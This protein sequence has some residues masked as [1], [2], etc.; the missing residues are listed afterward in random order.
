MA[1]IARASFKKITELNHL[2]QLYFSTVNLASRMPRGAAAGQAQMHTKQ[3]KLAKAVRPACLPIS[4][5]P[6]DDAPSKLWT[7]SSYSATPE[8][9][10][11]KILKNSTT[12]TT[13]LYFI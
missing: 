9:N 2:L 12:T 7:P 13:T 3:A 10:G 1:Q 8:L 5:I 11:G 4:S 6:D